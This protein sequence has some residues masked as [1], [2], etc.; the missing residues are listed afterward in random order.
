MATGKEGEPVA[1]RDR[2]PRM[3]ARRGQWQMAFGVALLV[4]AAYAVTQ[5]VQ[6]DRD[7]FGIGINVTAGLLALALVFIGNRARKRAR[8]EQPVESSSLRKI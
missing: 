4:R 7:L 2:V 3:I 5:D 8:R 6:R 1:V